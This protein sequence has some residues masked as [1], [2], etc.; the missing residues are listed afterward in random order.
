MCSSRAVCIRDSRKYPECAPRE[1]VQRA[2]DHLEA[3]FCVAT[4]EDAL[5]HH[6]KPEIFNTDLGSQFTDAAFTGVLADNGITR[7]ARRQRSAASRSRGKYELA[8]PCQ[9]SEPKVKA[10]NFA[11]LPK[12]RFDAHQALKSTQYDTRRPRNRACP[13][14]AP[15]EAQDGAR[16]HCLPDVGS[17]SDSVDRRCWLDVWF[18]RKRIRLGDLMSKRALRP[19]SELRLL[20]NWHG[21]NDRSRGQSRSDSPDCVLGSKQIKI[22]KLEAERT[23]RRE[24]LQSR[25]I[26]SGFSLSFQLQDARS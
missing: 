13:S 21:Q 6:G 22:A 1:A 17:G 9:A 18:T 19:T 8:K 24:R 14:R 23:D 25:L 16:L 20:P 7:A 26:S 4:L 2:R 3:T 12:T 5:A 15:G 10:L 11:G